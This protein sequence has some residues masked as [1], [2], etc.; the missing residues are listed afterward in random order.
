[1]LIR[2]YEEDRDHARLRECV[3][4]LQDY[5]RGLDPRLPTG[6]SVADACL[7]VIFQS[8]EKYHGKVFVAVI[9][10]EVV[11]YA[12]VL[13]RARAEGPEEGPREFALVS[14][15]A[16][17]EAYRNRGIGKRLLEASE[18]YAREADARWLRVSVLARNAVAR[19]VYADCGF[20][21]HE[22]TLEKQVM[23]SRGRNEGEAA[24]HLL[25]T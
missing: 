11:G 5:E 8:C 15:L 18:Q 16:V 24:D 23:R 13:A 7:K 10:E 22:I 3:I 20:R 6:A 19:A 4:A 21:E 14:D 9:D 1:M 25:K 17:L 2:A 12:A